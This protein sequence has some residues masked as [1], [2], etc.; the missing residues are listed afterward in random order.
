MLKKIFAF[1]IKIPHSLITLMRCL[2]SQHWQPAFSEPSKYYVTDGQLVS[3]PTPLYL[4][5][6]KTRSG[7]TISLAKNQKA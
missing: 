2:F 4:L 6:K 7:G 1:L 3:L 5:L